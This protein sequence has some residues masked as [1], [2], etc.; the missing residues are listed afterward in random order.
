M[1]YMKVLCKTNENYPELELGSFYES[2]PVVLT[3]DARNYNCFLYR[4]LGLSYDVSFE[5]EADYYQLPEV[6][7]NTLYPSGLFFSKEDARDFLI[8]KIVE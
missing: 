8:N 5:Q 1:R 4:Y 2:I 6:S 3:S 7:E